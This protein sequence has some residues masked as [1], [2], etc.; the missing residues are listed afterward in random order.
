MANHSMMDKSRNINCLKVA[1]ISTDYPPLRTSAA[2]QMRDL[3]IEV[4][5]QGHNPIV[6]VPTAELDMSTSVELM[7]G[8]SILRLRVPR[9]RDIGYARRT[10]AEFI[11]P[12]LLILRLRQST[13][14]DVKWD[15]VAWYSPTIFFGPL[16]KYLKTKTGCYTYLILRD[17]FPEWAVDLGLMRRGFAYW[18][19]KGVAR[20]QYEVADTIGVQTPANL[21]YMAQWATPPQRTVEVLNNWQSQTP[22]IGTTIDIQ[23]TTLSG[24]KIVVYI[25]NMGIAQGMDILIDLAANLVDKKEI[26]FLFV[27]RGSEVMRLK[28]RVLSLGIDNVIFSNEVASKEMP[29][30]LKQCFLGLISLDPRHKSHNIPGKF[31]TYLLAGLPILAHVNRGTDL[32]KLINNNGVGR[33]F[34]DTNNL[35]ELREFVLE[36]C[37]DDRIRKNISACSKNLALKQYSPKRA[38]DQLMNAVKSKPSVE[39]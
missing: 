2:V 30:L 25:G 39:T 13:Y 12:I 17:I 14:A 20:L 19:F 7:D 29:G 3:A 35:G 22:D 21:T 32:E 10:L 24:R 9:F 18:I 15:L 33:A 34:N 4:K 37:G 5:K 11:L 8:I 23:R 36:M 6:I 38:V 16:I 28:E 31:L 1:L 26:G 27:G